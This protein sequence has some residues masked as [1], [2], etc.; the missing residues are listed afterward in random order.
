ME[1]DEM[2]GSERYQSRQH[3]EIG[4]WTLIK[5][6]N[7]RIMKFFHSNHAALPYFPRYSYSV[8]IL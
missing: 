2:C 6:E 7:L 8:A 5:K 3:V 1:C 4:Q